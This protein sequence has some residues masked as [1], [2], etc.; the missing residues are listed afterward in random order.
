MIDEI[1]RAFYLEV[2]FKF[3]IK[4]DPNIQR[5]ITASQELHL[6]SKYHI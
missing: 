3:R 6:Q 4:N 2:K 5:T 1:Q